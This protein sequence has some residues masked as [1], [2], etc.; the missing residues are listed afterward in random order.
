ML[1]G[2]CILAEGGN[3][4]S[5]LPVI[6]GDRRALTNTVGYN[7][8]RSVLRYLEPRLTKQED[9][10]KKVSGVFFSPKSFDN[11]PR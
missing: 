8:S 5:V 4:T 2:V 6:G 3:A 1:S 7:Y 10:W 11:A 9:V